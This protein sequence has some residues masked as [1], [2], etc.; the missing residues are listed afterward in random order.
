MELSNIQVAVR[1]RPF[2]ER[3][4]QQESKCVVKMY[5]NATIV[6]S[7]ATVDLPLPQQHNQIFTFD[8]S[9]WSNHNTPNHTNTTNNNNNNNN[10]NNYNTTAIENRTSSLITQQEVYETIGKPILQ[11]VLNGYNSCLLAYGQ[12][13]CL[14]PTTEVRMFDGQIKQA[15]HVQVGD[16]ILGNDLSAR[17]VLELFS[18]TSQMYK[19]TQT[20]GG[21]TYRVNKDHVLTLVK[22]YDWEI[23]DDMSSTTQNYFYAVKWNNGHI[24]Y[25]P[26]L[27]LAQ[28]FCKKKFIKTHLIDIPVSK[29]IKKSAAWKSL[30]KG[31]RLNQDES[32]C[33]NNN[34]CDFI[35]SD[36]EVIADGRG[37]YNGF[38]IDG[39]QRFLLADFT[40]THN[41]G[42]TY[43]MMGGYSDESRGLIPRICADLFEH[44]KSTPNI[45]F[46]VEISYLEIY[47]EQIRDLLNSDSNTSN[48]KV[49]EHPTTGPYVDGITL[50]PV[51]NFYAVH[52]FMLFGSKKRVTAATKMNDTSSRSHAVF[53]VYV[54]QYIKA[55]ENAPTVTRASENAQPI[56]K[57]SETPHTILSQLISQ[58]KLCLVDL[59]GSER[60]KDSG[61]TGIHLKE[62]A[63][64]NTSLTMLGRVI[65]TLAKL[66][67]GGNDS[68]SN[69][70]HSSNP[71]TPRYIV[72]STDT[73]LVRDAG[74]RR[75]GSGTNS[76]HNSPRVITSSISEQK[77]KEHKEH[78]EHKEKDHKES[79]IPHIPFR[80]SI[81]T[82]LLKD[83]L[84]GNSKTVMLAAISPSHLNYD[85]TV[86]TLQYAARAK[87]I[88]NK[89]TINS[90]NTDAMI[91]KL[92]AELEQLQRQYNAIQGTQFDEVSLDMKIQID[93][94]QQI[95]SGLTTTWDQCVENNLLLQNSTINKYT[96]HSKTIKTTLSVPFLVNISADIDLDKD[97]IYYLPPG[98]FEGTDIHPCVNCTIEN[99]DG[100]ITLFPRDNNSNILINGKPINNIEQPINNI[101][102]PLN[103]GDKIQ[104]NSIILKFKI[105]ILS[106]V[107]EP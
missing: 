30:H 13:G 77:D 75:R 67:G 25:F 69:R 10:N 6:T 20:N 106:I 72:P 5:K 89:V 23:I 64:I 100:N 53:I 43:S 48:L 1:V 17:H 66:S 3:E 76:G 104:V 57:I 80:D 50:V 21:M 39:N 2:N 44:I 36:I 22:K 12:T 65:S 56:S 9:F 34:K 62:A 19:I 47:A 58:S 42:K 37:P 7:P 54:N 70:G 11:N 93:A 4:L 103:H 99:K 49:R 59:A 97:L 31:I 26:T 83:S 79:I 14:D 98:H 87:E 46:K 82:W 41:S 60:V 63:D 91:S 96:E 18:G 92:N 74:S 33:T 78:K 38:C 55:S 15:C 105:P 51:E 107:S 101:G 52:Q 71:N 68:G 88:V 32:K 27:S 24:K 85:E 81:L 95:L 35:Y 40:V 102:Q 29:Y 61:V 94:K 8:H 73:L 45:E 86:N 84:G 90:S 28:E 16:V